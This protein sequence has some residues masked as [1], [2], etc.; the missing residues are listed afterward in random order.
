MSPN[1]VNHEILWVLEF[2]ER[3]SKRVLK[4]T[5][6]HDSHNSVTSLF[7]ISVHISFHISI[8]SELPSESEPMNRPVILG[9]RDYTKAKVI[10]RKSK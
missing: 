7:A 2:S 1:N 3:I 6:S 9:K 8:S 4:P 10:K 5:K